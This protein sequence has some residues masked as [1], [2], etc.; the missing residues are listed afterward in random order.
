MSRFEMILLCLCMGACTAPPPVDPLALAGLSGAGYALVGTEAQ[1]RRDVVG[2]SLGGEGYRVRIAPGGTLTGLY[3]GE[4]FSG[5]WVFR[6]DG[7]YCQSLTATLSGP[8]SACY[9]VAVKGVDIR[10]IPVP[11]GV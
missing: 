3:H 10:L 7:K 5:V 2:Q 6:N 8:A 9:W 11:A 4:T 1:F